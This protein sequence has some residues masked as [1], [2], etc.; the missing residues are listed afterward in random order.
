MLQEAGLSWSL[1][2]SSARLQQRDDV[3]VAA[4]TRKVEGSPPACIHAIDVGAT[5]QEFLDGIDVTRV[6]CEHQ[7]RG[8][9]SPVA[10]AWQ[11]THTL[12][13]SR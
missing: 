3:L 12:R 10:T 9:K 11:A 6:S 7:R 2:P 4:L 13:L 1:R 5:L 8:A